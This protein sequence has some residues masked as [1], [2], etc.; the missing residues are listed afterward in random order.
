M[1]A[2]DS[3]RDAVRGGRDAAHG[4]RRCRTASRIA[5][6][7][8]SAA[9]TPQRERARRPRAGGQAE[10]RVAVER[11]VGRRDTARATPAWAIRA[12]IPASALSSAASVTT[13]TSVVLPGAARRGCSGG[14]SMHP[15]GRAEEAR[16]PGRRRR[17]G[18]SP[19]SSSTSPQAFTTASAATV[20][21][22]V[23]PPRGRPR[24]RPCTS[25]PARAAC[26]PWRRCP[27]PRCP[28]RA[29]PPRAASQAA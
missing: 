17:P 18:R 4:R 20:G 29:G 12:T 1:L 25:P 10:D 2:G 11:R 26:R 8:A 3:A 23:Q 19:P 16:A 27:R 21:P 14:T 5:A 15:P 24:A 6:A 28:P 7:A 22:V 9:A 13:H